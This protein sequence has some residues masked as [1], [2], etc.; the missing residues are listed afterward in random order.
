MTLV[1]AEVGPNHNGS[2]KEAMALID[3][4]AEVGAD[5]VK[6]Q[7]HLAEAETLENAPPPPHFET[8]ETRYE[9]YK[10][11]AFSYRQ[12]FIIRE[13]TR[14]K[15]L[16]FIVSPFSTEAVDLME[17][18]D[19]DA[20]KIASG[21]VTNIPLL[22]YIASKG[23]L[24]ILS[25]GMSNWDEFGKAMEVFWDNDLALLQCT[26][27]YPCQYDHVGLNLIKEL[28]DKYLYPVGLSDHTDTI[29]IPIAAVALGATVIEKHFTLTNDIDTPDAK[30]SL[31]PD[32]FKQMVEGIRAVELALTPVDKEDIDR[33]ERMK[34][35]FQKSITSTV[36]IR[37]D[38]YITEDMI[39]I[40]KPGDG[41]DPSFYEDI[42]Y[43]KVVRDIP[44]DS[45]IYERDI[46]W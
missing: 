17:H 36:F 12:W 37:K 25:S 32:K 19:V 27:E 23:K 28:G 16:R 13:H 31:T 3:A 5:A 7:C 1:I 18:F 11:I 29:F 41:L 21:E 42:M 34:S 38:A 45:L 4:A 14:K 39:R 20:Y 8:T 24:V 26:S 6:F 15:G 44:K 46:N 40:R 2:L 43:K 9:F 30:F 33:Y 22:E 35:I 10:R